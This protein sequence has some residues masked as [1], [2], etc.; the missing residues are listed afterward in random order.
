M[1]PS[2]GD[3]G[4]LHLH[5][6]QEG[7]APLPRRREVR[8]TQNTTSGL[9]T[10]NLLPSFQLYCCPPRLEKGTRSL[11]PS[12]SQRNPFQLFPYPSLIQG[13]CFR[14]NSWALPS[15]PLPLSLLG[16]GRAGEG[17]V[18][19]WA[20]VLQCILQPP[21]ATAHDRAFRV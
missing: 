6:L 1:D 5:S 17:L 3:S 19:R 21:L 14:R 15:T 8:R 7:L 16:M 2:L 20:E 18:L 11:M 12:E 10:P 4:P 13:L 9:S